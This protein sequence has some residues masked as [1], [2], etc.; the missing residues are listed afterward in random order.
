[1]AGVVFVGVTR[2]LHSPKIVAFLLARRVGVVCCC[3]DR[4]AKKK[5]KM[6]TREER[7]IFLAKFF[8]IF[9]IIFNLFFDFCADFEIGRAFHINEACPRL[10]QRRSSKDPMRETAHVSV[11]YLAQ[12]RIF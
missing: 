9:S 2:Q 8:V 12:P 5:K 11:V 3:G 7:R 4:E 1:M 6:P 10:S